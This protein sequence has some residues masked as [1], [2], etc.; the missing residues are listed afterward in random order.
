MIQKY[1]RIS[2]AVGIPGL[3]LQIGSQVVINLC[4]NPASHVNSD[5]LEGTAAYG[6]LLGTVLL[7][8]GLCYYA[9]A[10][11]Y[12]AVYGCLGLLSCIGLIILAVMKDKTVPP[13]TPRVES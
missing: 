5:M 1:N 13:P 6:I 9:K 12:S 8:I 10:K 4:K 2:L 7:I 3:L 11:G